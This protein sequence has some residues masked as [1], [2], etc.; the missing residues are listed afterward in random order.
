VEVEAVAGRYRGRVVL[1]TILLAV[2]LAAVGDA[3]GA[4]AAPLAQPPRAPNSAPPGIQP[5]TVSPAKA[6]QPA[7]PPKGQ[8]AGQ[9]AKP[10]KPPKGQTAGQP[11]KP[12]APPKGQTAG[13]P[14][15]PAKPPTAQPAKPAKPPT[16]QPA[17]PAKP[18]KPPTAQ[19][20]KPAKPPTAQPAKPAKPPTPQPAKPPTGQTAG[21]P[22]EPPTGQTAGQPAKPPTAQGPKPL[23]TEVLSEVM[24]RPDSGE[25]ASPASPPATSSGTPRPSVAAP[26]LPAEDVS[27]ASPAVVGDPSAP[28]RTLEAGPA[29]PSVTSSQ[30]RVSATSEGPRTAA[31]APDTAGLVVSTGVLTSGRSAAPSSQPIPVAPASAGDAVVRDAITSG[32]GPS[33][34][35]VLGGGARSLEVPFSLIAAFGLYVA[36]QRR[37]RVSPLP[38][39]P[40]D[41]AAASRDVTRTGGDDDRYLL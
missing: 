19:P 16:A 26:K 24:E 36:V 20:A 21:Q 5:A 14:A 37:L 4:A 2:A 41:P 15:R 9:P 28:G 1:V 6:A 29:V 17:K 30:D 33:L 10:A 38:M 32:S 22:A 12:A 7:A 31:A 39:R 8:S 27:S 34:V 11:A 23:E 25:V 35:D 18:A 13:Q 3:S 40:A